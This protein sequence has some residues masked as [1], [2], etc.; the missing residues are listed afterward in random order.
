MFEIVRR[1]VRRGRAKIRRVLSVLQKKCFIYKKVVRKEIGDSND[2]V[3]E[4]WIPDADEASGSVS[5]TV[6]RAGRY[7][8]RWNNVQNVLFRM[9][10]RF[11]SFGTHEMLGDIA[12]HYRA[13]Y[14]PE[15]DSYLSV[16]GWTE[17]PMVEFY[18]VENGG[19]VRPEK[20]EYKKTII[21]DGE[22]YDIYTRVRYDAPSIGD[23]SDFSQY[24]SVRRTK[25]TEGYIDISEHF[26]AWED[27]GMDMGKLYEI[28]L[29][30]E[31]CNGGSGSASIVRNDMT[32]AH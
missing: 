16:Y 12:L 23:S 32:W 8:C 31:G 27:I 21:S 4:V 13:R 3:Y 18:V 19:M 1:L 22:E 10:Y 26:R 7:T 6:K 2:R 11:G 28:S 9:G 15:G 17:E 5:M 24:W 29:C 14:E 20:R 30:V 25:R